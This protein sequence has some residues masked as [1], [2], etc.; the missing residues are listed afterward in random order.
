ML[1][2]VTAA[3]AATPTAGLAFTP[4]SRADL[5]WV[6]D[7]RTSGTPVGEFDGF[8]DPALAA[9]GGVW[10]GDRFAVLGSLGVARLTSTTWDGETWRQRHWGV[11]RPGVDV[12]WAAMPRDADHAIVPFLTLG[13]HGDIPS[14]RDTSNGY[15][16]EEAA[17]ADETA[18]ID[19]LRLGGVGGRLGAGVDWRPIPGI[20]VGA[21][22]VVEARWATLRSS[23]ATIAS[24]WISSQ[25]E[26]LF[27]FEWGKRDVPPKP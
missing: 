13:G 1:W 25:V 18:T 24:S 23:D 10:L 22:Y 20:A 21:Q 7:E 5:A 11:I 19:R 9:Y 8:V 17:Q 27:A 14:A 15:S 3:L 2:F 6:A 12:R 4:L 26:L 16:P